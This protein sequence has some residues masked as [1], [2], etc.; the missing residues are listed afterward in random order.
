M[1]SKMHSMK[2]SSFSLRFV[3]HLH[4]P[5]L[6]VIT[7]PEKFSANPEEWFGS[8]LKFYHIAVKF[9]WAFKN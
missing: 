3:M 2:D 1:F 9:L 4:L 7:Y 6:S 8:K 5:V